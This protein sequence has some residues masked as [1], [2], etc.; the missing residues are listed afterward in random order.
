MSKRTKKILYWA[1]VSVLILVILFCAWMIIDKLTSDARNES[2]YND[3]ASNKNQLSGTRP[4]IPT[5]TVTTKPTD[6][7]PT[8]PT[9][10]PPTRPSTEDNILPEY[11]ESYKINN[12]MVGWIQIEGTTVD[13]PVVQ[14]KYQD[15]YYLRRNFYR[16]SA[17]CGTIYAREECNIYPASDNIVLYGHNMRNGTMFHD[18][19][20]Y[21][22]QK[23]WQN[24]RYVYFDTLTEYRTYEIFAVFV[25]TA[26]P[27]V[28]FRYH[29]FN[30]TN[31][32]KAYNKYI[33]QCKELAFY[34]TGITP[35]YGDE[36]LTLSTCDKEIGYGKNGRLVVIARRVV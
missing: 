21:K 9:Q 23:F 16:Q 4:P 36:L 30:D 19:I 34:D 25:T 13:Y 32:S 20:K 31:S 3:L 27:S 8:D 35:Q 7:Q 22:D 28:G 11:L 12:D 26:D 1:I 33:S 10:P 18:L 15:D 2:A 6:G 17:T 5:G 14:S 29:L 24:H